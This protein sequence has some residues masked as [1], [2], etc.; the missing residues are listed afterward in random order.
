LSELKNKIIGYYK[1]MYRPVD[2]K[3]IKNASK[4]SKFE[5][6]EHELSVLQYQL[7]LKRK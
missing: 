7:S 3:F 1:A 4:N 5:H 2:E 6:A